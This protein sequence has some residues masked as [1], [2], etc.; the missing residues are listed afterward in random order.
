MQY[1][2]GICA[3]VVVVLGLVIR[4][5]TVDAVTA[6]MNACVIMT[7][8]AEHYSGDVHSSEA[9]ALFAPGCLK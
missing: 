3:I 4:T 5:N 9:W 8:Y 6:S 7:A 2:F 1:F